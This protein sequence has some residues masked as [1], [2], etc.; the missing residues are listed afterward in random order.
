MSTKY[1]SPLRILHYDDFL[2]K[3]FPLNRGYKDFVY[4]LVLTKI[5]LLFCMFLPTFNNP[6][7]GQKNIPSISPPSL[8]FSHFY[9]S[10]R[11]NFLDLF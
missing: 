6:I 5:V 3:I 10:N 7:V 8:R 11:N 2:P 9:K 1:F 4:F